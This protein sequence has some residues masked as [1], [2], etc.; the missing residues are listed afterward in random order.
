MSD[1]NKG[2]HIE[3]QGGGLTAHHYPAGP[4]GNCQCTSSAMGAI[5]AAIRDGKQATGRPY[6]MGVRQD[7]DAPAHDCEWEWVYEDSDCNGLFN[8]E[9]ITGAACAFRYEL[10]PGPRGQRPRK[11]RCSAQI[12]LDEVIAYANHGWRS[13]F[14]V[15]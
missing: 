3:T 12:G 11:R 5:S 2:C 1:S 14:R 6:A 10:P 15:W 8:G 13:M 7:S 4:S 9:T